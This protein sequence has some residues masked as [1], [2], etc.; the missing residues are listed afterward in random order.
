MISLIMKLEFS[1]DFV[2]IIVSFI[3]FNRFKEDTFVFYQN[4]D[5]VSTISESSTTRSS[6]AESLKRETVRQFTFPVMLGGTCAL[7]GRTVCCSQVF[8]ISW[9]FWVLL[10]N[11]LLIIRNAAFSTIAD[12]VVSV[13]VTSTQLVNSR[14]LSDRS[15]FKTISC[16]PTIY[17][18]SNYY[19]FRIHINLL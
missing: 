10:I 1:N 15:V 6:N 19:L 2:V 12:F 9:I 5:P 14:L 11:I 3:F 18:F 16:L 17:L 13:F 8:F 7:C 4:C